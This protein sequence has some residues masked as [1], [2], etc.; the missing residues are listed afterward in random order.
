MFGAKTRVYG[1]A[2]S[3]RK[4]S[5]STLSYPKSMTSKTELRL[6]DLID[7][8]SISVIT[9]MTNFSGISFV[10]M[11]DKSEDG[12]ELIEICVD[13]GACDTVLP[14]RMLQG[15]KL[16]QTEASRAGE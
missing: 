3:G 1:D 12:W 5:S 4:I 13:S 7:K 9:K 2:L 6:E 14:S 8:P 10:T 11:P 15:V 16:E